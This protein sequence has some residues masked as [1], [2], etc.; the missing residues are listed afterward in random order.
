MTP[1]TPSTAHHLTLEDV[2]KS[3][4]MDDDIHHAPTQLICLENTLDGEVK[5]VTKYPIF[6]ISIILNGHHVPDFPIG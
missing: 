3:W 4:I 5:S 1:V 2:E 6:K